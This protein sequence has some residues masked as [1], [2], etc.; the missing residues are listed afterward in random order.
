M[1]HR[2]VLLAGGLAA[3]LTANASVGATAEDITQRWPAGSIR[4]VE[5]AEAARS[6]VRAVEIAA[7]QA[8]REEQAR[9]ERTFFVNRCMENARRS[10]ALAQQQARRVQ[11][12]AGEVLRRAEVEE[13]RRQRAEHER[14]AREDE[15]RARAARERAEAAAQRQRELNDPARAAGRADAA[16]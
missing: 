9:C 6:A 11:V 15:E 8:W 13:R 4:T 16:A 3:V 12:E 1:R 14:A 2:L 10:H 7:E 5:Q